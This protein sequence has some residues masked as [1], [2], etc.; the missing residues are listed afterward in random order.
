MKKTSFI[1]PTHDSETKSLAGAAYNKIYEDIL[2]CELHPGSKLGMAELQ[3]RYQLG[4]GPIREAL[5]RLSSENLVIAREQK[6]YRVA[7]ID[8]AEIQEVLIARLVVELGALRLSM[9]S[10]TPAWEGE[11]LSAFHQLDRAP[12]PDDD[13]QHAREW[14]TAHRRFHMV[15]LSNC[16][17]R[18]LLKTAERLFDQSERSR[19]LRSKSLTPN[20]LEMIRKEHKRILNAV[21]DDQY[22][23]AS[24][25]LEQ[26]YTRT[27]NDTLKA[28]RAN[29]DHA[30]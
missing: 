23:N 30:E 5:A 28:L 10:R 16:G 12:F 3:K 21:L 8:Q 20:S 7:P 17:S 18:I 11:L 29:L 25:H 22:E 19:F 2:Q 4:L 9:Q 14:R 15:L 27:T 13:A 1:L 6:G 24:K 26:H